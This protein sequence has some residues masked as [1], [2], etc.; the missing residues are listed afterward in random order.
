MRLPVAAW[1]NDKIIRVDMTRGSVSVENY[2]AEW[3]YLGGRALIA[4]I[5]LKQ[6][7]PQCDPLGPDNV[8]VIA[9]GVL[10]GS[11]APTSG[12]LSIGCK[13][14]LTGGI[15]EANVG[16][17]PAQDLMKLGYR[18]IVITGKPAGV[19]HRWGLIIDGETVRLVAADEFKGMWNYACCEKLLAQHPESASAISIGPAGEHMLAAASIACTDRSKGRHPARHAARGGVGAVMGA[20]CLKWILIDPGRAPLRK[21]EEQKAF[22]GYK[23]SFSQDYLS[24]GRHDAFKYGTSSLV[25]TA[26]MLHA[27]PYKN[28]TSG[29]NP[30]W[31]KLDGARILESFETRGGGMHNC[32]TGCIVRCSNVVHDEHG[33][34]L[35]SAL[36]FETITLLGSNCAINDWEE[37]ARLD[38]LCDEVGIDTI[39]TG[40]AFAVYM[41]SGGLE[42]GDAEGVKAIIRNDVANATE[43]GRQIGN[44]ALAIG[45]ARGHHRIPHNKGQA[46][47]AFDPRPFKATGITYCSSAMG[48]DHTAGLVFDQDLTEAEAVRRSQELQI[49]N[50]VGDST[51]FCI[52]LGPT[53]EETAR[54][55]SPFFGEKITAQQMADIGWQ[56]LADEWHFNDGAGFTHKDDACPECI[57]TEG[58]GPNQSMVFDISD[59]AIAAAKVRQPPRDKLYNT[60]PAG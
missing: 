36:E 43:L 40:A 31:E 51:G 48:A 1:D 39:E 52:F 23:K 50:A 6:C 34:Y 2:P 44:G 47:P 21:A 17:E 60:S 27:F 53:L 29:Q 28:R 14:P 12:R 42:W 20:K 46:I 49:I 18:A 41:D 8:L 11:M 37:I 59:D 5:L 57:R 24:N 7:P 38:R 3:K 4:R 16:G 19:N 58:I 56:C 35:T 26:N 15:K 32:L 54:Y 25:P 22:A 13:S 10:A 30:E 55:L 9:P 45:T 33:H